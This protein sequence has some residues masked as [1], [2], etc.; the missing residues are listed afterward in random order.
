[1]QFTALSAPT[2]ATTG[3]A[4]FTQEPWKGHLLPGRCRTLFSDL[5]GWTTT[6][7]TCWL[8]IWEG[9]GCF[10]YPRSMSFT[11]TETAR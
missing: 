5:A 6:P 10:G 1:M 7:G 11:R 4:P 3:P 9:W 2:P 8:G